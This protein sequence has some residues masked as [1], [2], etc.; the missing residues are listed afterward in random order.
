[1]GLNVRVENSDSILWGILSAPGCECT[2]KDSELLAAGLYFGGTSSAAFKGLNNR[3][4]APEVAIPAADRK[5]KFL[6]CGVGA[7][8][9]YA[10]ENAKVNIERCTFGEALVFGKGK[11]EARDSVCDG[12]GGYIGAESQGE[13]YLSGCRINCVVVAREQSLITLEN[14]TVIGNVNAAGKSTIRL[15]NTKVLGKVDKEAG[16]KITTEDGRKP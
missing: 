5:L 12:S 2:L 3:S 7:W 11:I 13:L 1:M 9:F 16:A 15:I 10:N 4:E 6:N 8:N 14:C